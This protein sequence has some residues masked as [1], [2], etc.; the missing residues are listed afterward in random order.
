MLD[1]PSRQLFI[2]NLLLFDLLQSSYVHAEH[3]IAVIADLLTYYNWLYQVSE[4]EMAKEREK[5]LKY[6][7]GLSKIKAA[8]ASEVS[9]SRRL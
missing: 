7:E 8:R 2:P 5:E 3:E 4:E 9:L 1:I 6:Q